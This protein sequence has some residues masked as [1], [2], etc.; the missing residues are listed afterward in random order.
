MDIVQIFST[1]CNGT[2]WKYIREKGRKD[3]NKLY[4]IDFWFR[5][6]YNKVYYNE[7]IDK[8]RVGL[9][10][11]TK[12]YKERIKRKKAGENMLGREKS[13]MMREQM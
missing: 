2:K 7:R 4:E 5:I 3:N 12:G 9:K 13:T 8:L 1:K 10:I 6:L 11:R